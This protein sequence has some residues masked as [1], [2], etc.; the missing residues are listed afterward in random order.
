MN[1]IKLIRTF[2][3]S[4]F[5]V[6]MMMITSCAEEGAEPDLPGADRDK[7][8]G[9]WLCKE[10][11]NGSQ[12]AAFTINIQKI[13][14]NDSVKV[15]NFSNVGSGDY[16]IWLISGNSITI[17]AQTVAGVDFGG[18]GFYSSGDL[19]L[20]YTSDTE[21]ISALCTPN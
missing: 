16:A 15:S 5:V 14:Q 1:P 20:N 13:G 7:Y 11:V 2:T 21:T 12:V 9:S 4:V 19:D 17:P 8:V 10:F 3:F 18:T 6:S